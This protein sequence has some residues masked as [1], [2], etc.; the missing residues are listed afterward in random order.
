MKASTLLALPMEHISEAAVVIGI[1]VRQWFATR[2]SFHDV[3]TGGADEI[4]LT[5]YEIDS[6]LPKFLPVMWA[7][8]S[9]VGAL[10]AILRRFV[11]PYAG[12]S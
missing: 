12:S 4:A 10:R 11:G 2:S 5:G 7:E 3:G 6:A 1:R 8:N 9:A